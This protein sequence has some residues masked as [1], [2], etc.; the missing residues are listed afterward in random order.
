M[1]I[2][3]KP[4]CYLLSTFELMS[5]FSICKESMKLMSMSQWRH[6]RFFINIAESRSIAHDYNH[7]SDAWLPGLG[8]YFRFNSS[9]W[10]FQ[11]ARHVVSRSLC[12]PSVLTSFFF[13]PKRFL[14]CG[15][16]L[17]I[18]KN[19]VSGPAMNI[20]LNTWVQKFS[21]TNIC[22]F[23]VQSLRQ[24]SFAH[25]LGIIDINKMLHVFG[26]SI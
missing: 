22:S 25:W 16:N 12:F 15:H 7:T 9:W 19:T 14:A 1:L 10:C 13:S 23:C 5:I 17:H 20:L 4:H 26:I 6:C 2:L 11:F 24:Q 18:L 21:C 8:R 3:K